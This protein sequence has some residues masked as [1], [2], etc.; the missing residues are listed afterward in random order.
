MFL[1]CSPR[2]LLYRYFEH[3]PRYQVIG[4]TSIFVDTR[5]PARK[6]WE[7]YPTDFEILTKAPVSFHYIVDGHHL[8]FTI[9]LAPRPHFR[10]L[11]NPKSHI[12]TIS[13]LSKHQWNFIPLLHK[14]L[15]D[16]MNTCEY[17]LQEGDAVLFDN[18]RVLRIQR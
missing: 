10:H 14:I 3:P 7:S 16:P 18:R 5:H 17:T 13:P 1:F 8:H 15:D 6:L 12:S 4:G 9:S 2:F 11:L